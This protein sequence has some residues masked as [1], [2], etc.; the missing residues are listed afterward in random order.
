MKMDIQRLRNLTTGRLHTEMA[1]IYDDLGDIMGVR[2]KLFTHMLPAANAA[3]KPWL[4]ERLADARFWDG[5]WD[6][7]H[8]GEVDIP[9]PTKAER[10]A[11]EERF[12]AQPNPLVG[13]RMLIIEGGCPMNPNVSPEDRAA[14]AAWYGAEHADR[15][16]ESIRSCGRDA[17]MHI[18]ELGE[19]TFV[20]LR[21]AKNA[22]REAALRIF[23]G[24]RL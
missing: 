3:V 20:E 14:L 24:G 18:T 16:I 4:R 9:D 19:T 23:K 17:E 5:K 21:S 1:D 8:L 15:V 7:T 12:L 22:A 2:G 13:K 10:K 6:T 11:M